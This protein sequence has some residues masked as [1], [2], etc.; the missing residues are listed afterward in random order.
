VHRG[1]SG[2]CGLITGCT[3]WANYLTLRSDGQFALADQTVSS[4]GGGVPFTYGWSAPPNEHGSYEIQSNARIRLLFA[5]GSVSVR[6]IG[7]QLAKDGRPD[8]AGAGVLL[9]DTNFYTDE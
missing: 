7:I 1:F 8:P 2:F 4:I 5:D 9:D 6:T 3:T